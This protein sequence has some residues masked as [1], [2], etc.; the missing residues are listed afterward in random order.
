MGDVAIRLPNFSEV[1]RDELR[2]LLIRFKHYDWP[3]PAMNRRTRRAMPTAG[4]YECS[5]SPQNQMS[6]ESKD[7]RHAI[8]RTMSARKRRNSQYFL[9]LVARW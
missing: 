7:S 3:S 6:G 5:R 1:G 9:L 8:G 4:Y 2:A